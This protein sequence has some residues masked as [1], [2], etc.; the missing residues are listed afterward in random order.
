[1]LIHWI[2]LATRPNMNDREKLSVLQHFRDPE[3]VFYADKEA[4]RE[5]EGLSKSAVKALQDKDLHPAGDI[6]RKCSSKE[7]QIC[8]Y[9]D[10]N[11]PSRLRNIPDPP[12]VLYYKGR[13]PNLDSAPVIAIVG[14]R[15][16][17]LY[18]IQ[19]ARKISAQIARCGGIV[20]SGMASGVDGAAVAGAISAGGVSVGILGNGADV[21]YPKSNRSLFLDT[22]RYGCLISEF[23]PETPPYGWNFPK[24]N[25][26]ISGISD[27]VLVVEAPVRSGALITARNAAEQGRDVFVVPGNVDM[28]TCEGSNALLREGAIAVSKGWDV[29]SEYLHL[30]PETIHPDKRTVAAEFAPEPMLT[31]NAFADK[32]DLKVAQ[33]PASLTKKPSSDKKKE[34]IPIDNR[35]QQPYDDIRDALPPLTQEEE[36]IVSLLKD[37]ELLVDDVIAGAQLPA[38]TVLS[39]LTLLEVKG[40][41]ARRPGNRVALK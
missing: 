1:M 2:W 39:T 6:L 25:R 21:V 35:Q 15:K 32:N 36:T 27:G 10:A 19:I 18:G 26:V 4:Y 5:V 24:R 31:E 41:V 11:Y 12:L 34:K 16:A 17:S 20:V 13:I 30:Y 14:T 8:A 40:V 9:T 29:V 3:D 38:G 23:P 37:G 33:K 7:I 28:P 22:Q